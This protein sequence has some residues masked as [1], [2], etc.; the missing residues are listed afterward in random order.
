MTR[1]RAELALA[2][3]TV[4]WGTSFVVVKAVLA[5]V[6]PILFIALRFSLAAVVLALIYR[7][8]VKREGLKAGLIAGSLL[9]TAFACQTAGL[10]LTT[11]SRS[12]FLTSLS[13]PMVPLASPVLYRNRPRLLEVAGI[14]IA[15]MGMIL[16]TLPASPQ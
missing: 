7:G 10:G 11:P 15:S 16:M 6:S 3:V 4:I 5:D 13:V 2:A 1:G 8:A 9:F 12:A 14:A